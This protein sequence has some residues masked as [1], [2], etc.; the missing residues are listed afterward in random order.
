MAASSTDAKLAEVIERV[1]RMTLTAP[2]DDAAS[3]SARGDRPLYLESLAQELVME[4]A[5]PP[6]AVSPDQLER[7]LF[8]R[9]S[10]PTDQLGSWSSDP[11]A[12][13]VRWLM[14]S[15]ARARS[16]TR[17]T[18]SRDEA[19]AE[20]LAA[21]LATCRE[22]CVS[23]VGLLLNP[24]M[25][26]TFPQPPEA[27]LRGALQLYDELVDVPEGAPP[28]FLEEFGARHGDDDPAA[29]SATLEPLLAELA[30]GVRKTSILGEYLKPLTLL[31][32]LVASKPV[33]ECVAR[34]PRWCPATRNNGRAFEDESLLG[35]F[36]ALGALPD[37]V[38]ELAPA[39]PNVRETLF[40]NLDRRGAIEST[41]STS[42]AAV[43][44]AR[45]G[46]YQ[47]LYGMLRHGGESRE[48]V[49]RW[50]ACACDENAGRSKMQIQPLSCASHSGATNAAAVA[51]RLATPF[52]DPSSGKF[53]KIDADYARSLKCRI[54][55]GECTRLAADL[56][57]ARRDRED[58]GSAV[59]ARA[60]PYGFICECFF[61]ASRLNHLGFIK[62][63]AEHTQLAR[64]LQERSSQMNDVEGM[65]ESWAASVPGGP[66]AFQ[67]AQFDR[68]VEE[69]KGEL[70]RCKQNYTMFDATL[71][72]P[73]VLEEQMR[74]YRLTLKWLEWVA[75]GGE[76]GRAWHYREGDWG[77]SSDSILPETVPRSWALL[78]EYILDDVAEFLLYACRFVIR[79]S[80]PMF[81]ENQGVAVMEDLLEVFILLLGSPTYVK[82]PYLRAKF[83]EIVRDWLPREPVKETGS[84]SSLADMF[85][86]PLPRMYLVPAILRL[87]VD[88]EFTGAANQF[89]DK[90]NVR[91]QIGEICEYLWTE[92]EHRK[93]WARLAKKDAAFYMR[94]LNM[95]INDAIWLLDESMK[96]LPELREY[97][98]EAASSFTGLSERERQE[99][100]SANRQNERALRSDLMLAKVHVGMMGYTSKDIASPFLV[101][102]M[103]E[104]VAAMLNY[105]LLYLAGPERKKLKFADRDKMKELNWDPPEMLG[106][107]VDVYLHLFNADENGAFVAA[108]ASDGRSYRDEVMVET[109]NVLRQLGLRDDASIRAF[110]DL[111]ERARM[112]H[113][114][115][116]EEE[117]E[118][119]DFPD[120]FLDPILCTPMEDPVRLPSGEAMERS[121]IMRHLL[122]ESRNP[123][124]RQPLE[125]KDLVADDELRGRI[126][127]WKA[128]RRAARAAERK[129]SAAEGA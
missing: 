97:Y 117:A 86:Q 92:E 12:A 112:A 119:G 5:E 14:R 59:N 107:I 25:R 71:Q 43:G 52:S 7:A 89:Y 66:N 123:F 120:E 47:C 87:Y 18:R 53:K 28:G 114:A 40:T 8:A 55:L 125:E 34:H 29:L 79:G 42:R 4:G 17:K 81:F 76:N 124:N 118:L 121:S 63:A 49:V 24:A 116:E 62:C 45:D 21:A 23:Y 104:R 83:V 33:A 88:I 127:A 1:F 56:E 77:L 99:R 51:L 101:P 50:L 10:T 61:L 98:A 27:E 3:A 85:D 2:G 54:D 38:D 91:F 128:E 35:P 126:E 31:C 93:T 22:L 75:C 26:G 64:E 100:D 105:F 113:A 46:L 73:K 11:E 94:F 37:P 90:F 68:R 72:D 32:Q 70:E 44:V 122:T 30:N 84:Y 67:Q 60:E 57:E 96:K 39:Q 15:Y 106:M 41:Y 16:E 13:P 82:N 58:A 103:V 65:R 69:M 74:F 115:A 6:F 48:G 78:P 108:V 110:E 109:A 20:A 9:L 80:N 36:F 95:L 102:E 19:Y 129:K 111:A